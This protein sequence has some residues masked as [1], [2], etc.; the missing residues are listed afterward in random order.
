MLAKTRKGTHATREVNLHGKDAN[1]FRTWKFDGVEG[2]CGQRDSHGGGE[3]RRK[4][5]R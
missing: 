1:V 4:V 2:R 3:T 5:G